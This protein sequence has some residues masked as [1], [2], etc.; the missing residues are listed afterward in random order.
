M[1]LYFYKHPHNNFGDDLNAWLWD[2]FLPGLNQ[3]TIAPET[4]FIGIGTLL[5]SSIPDANE[6]AIFGTGVGYGKGLPQLDERWKFYCVRGPLSA[7]TLGLSPDLAVT[8]PGILVRRVT[9]LSHGRKAYP[10]SY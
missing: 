7:Q 4:M 8:D 9:Q 2:I 6:Y 1:K 3:A 10:F 5:N